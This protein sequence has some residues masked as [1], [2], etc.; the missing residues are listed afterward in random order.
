M[1]RVIA[2]FTSNPLYIL[3]YLLH[4]LSK[5]KLNLS[6]SLLPP[7]PFTLFS[8]YLHLFATLFL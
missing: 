1:T 3:P 5:I 8:L 7:K 4:N 2:C 6:F